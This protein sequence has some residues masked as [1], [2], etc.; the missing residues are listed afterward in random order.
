MRTTTSSLA[1]TFTLACAGLAGCTSSTGGTA[2]L[3]GAIEDATGDGVAFDGGHDAASGDAAHDGAKVDAA[4]DGATADS[5][6]DAASDT[7]TGGTDTSVA[8]VD[9]GVTTG[10][11]V[12]GY[13]VGY[14][15]NA[16]PIASIDWSGLTHIAFAPLVVNSHKSLDLP[17]SDS[18]APGEA[19]ATALATASP[20]PFESENER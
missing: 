1:F 8:S 2:K 17:Y 7:G 18:T 19:A 4:H 3:D 13:Y 15:I 16:Y 10:Q 11:W 14:G 12:L 20:V 9:S 5:S 6:H